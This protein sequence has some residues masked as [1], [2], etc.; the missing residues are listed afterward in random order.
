MAAKLHVVLDIDDTLVKHLKKTVWAT[1]PNQSDFEIVE[2]SNK[3]S[4]FVLRPHLREFMEFLRTECVT[5]IW[6]W[7]DYA[8][9]KQVASFL[10]RMYNVEFKDILSEEDALIS[11]KLHLDKGDP[12][13]KD[14]NYLWYDYNEKY[15]S[16]EVRKWVTEVRPSKID[17]INAERDAEGQELYAPTMK[18]FDG[19]APCNTVLIDDAAYNYNTSNRKNMIKVKPF[20]GKTETAATKGTAPVL[21]ASDTDLLKVIEILRGTRIPCEDNLEAPLFPE[22]GPKL[23]GRKKR[24]TQ[25]RR[26]LHK[27]TRK[28]KKGRSS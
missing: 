17:E 25:K 12:G 8:Y 9:A 26:K 28:V 18:L 19:Y 15:A 23:G 6:T 2:S 13:G 11:T 16:P 21:D 22:S 3:Q 20:G 5:S 14:L 24:A 1:V 10:N 7:S 27:K 4:V